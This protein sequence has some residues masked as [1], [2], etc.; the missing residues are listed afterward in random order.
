MKCTFCQN[1]MDIEGFECHHCG[2]RCKGNFALPRLAKLPGDMQQLAE[3]VLLAAGNLKE[4]S[5][6]QDVS[7]PTLRKRVDAL[8][9]AIEE[10]RRQDEQEI[11]NLLGEVENGKIRPEYAAR[12]ISEL[13]RGS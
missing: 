11:T 12:R 9:A 6:L 5:G 3:Q 7:Y 8:I 10:L 2:V 13:H 1:Q 4:V